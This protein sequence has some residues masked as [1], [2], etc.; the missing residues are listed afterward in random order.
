[1]AFKIPDDIWLSYGI[2][3]ADGFSAIA[4]EREAEEKTVE[5]LS[6]KV[7]IITGAAGGQGEAEA[8]LFVAEGARVAITDI[9]ERG[10]QV[11]AELGDAAMF[12]HHDISDAHR[13]TSL[14]VQR[15]A[16]SVQSLARMPSPA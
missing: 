5:R 12:L 11:A 13:S 14:R 2:W 8:R 6:G 9:Q 10:K 1:L 4:L 3:I 15:L 7:A 16:S